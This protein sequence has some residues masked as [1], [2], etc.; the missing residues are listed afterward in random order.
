MEDGIAP[1]ARKRKRMKRPR[2]RADIANHAHA[3]RE[4]TL[5]SA[6]PAMKANEIHNNGMLW[7][8]H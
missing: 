2:M 6:I 3:E 7:I 1:E 4:S 5:A 8:L